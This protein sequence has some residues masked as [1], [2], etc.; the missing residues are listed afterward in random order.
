MDVALNVDDSGN[1]NLGS[2]SIGGQGTAGYGGAG[3]PFVQVTNASSVYD[4][5]NGSA[6]FGTAYAPV[7]GGVGVD[8]VHGPNGPNTYSGIKVSLLT[9]LK[10]GPL[11]VVPDVHT[12]ISTTSFILPTFNIWD[13]L[14]PR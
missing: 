1:F 2:L 6:T 3:G 9:G 11:P 7:G 14:F 13:K 8:W 12:G 4:L 5:Q 10:T